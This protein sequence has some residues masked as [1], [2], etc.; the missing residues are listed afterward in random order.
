MLTINV[1]DLN[2]SIAF[3][4]ALGM[5]LKERWGD[6]YAQM[7]VEGMNIGLHPTG[8]SKIEKNSGNVSI[9]FTTDNFGLVK[10][11]LEE[12]GISCYERNE[13]GGQF[14]HFSDL[15]GT[16]LYFIQPKY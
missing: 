13:E 15:D 2:K 8:P 6:F 9:G 11:F 5:I 3:Y 10:N 14:I 12:R 16:S 1:L 4:E 7:K